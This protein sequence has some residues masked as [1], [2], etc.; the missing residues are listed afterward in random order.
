MNPYSAARNAAL[1]LVLLLA[2]CTTRSI[3][4]SGYPEG[5]RYGTSQVGG[6]TG[7]LSEFQVLGVTLD[8]TITEADIDAALKTKERPRLGPASR[9]LLI[10]SGADFP[11]APMLEALSARFSISSF[12]GKPP[13][14]DAGGV[15][16][17]RSLRLAAARGGYD[18][19]LC[20]WGILESERVNQ[21]TKYVSWV[22]IIGSAVPD[23][24]ERMRLR[25]KAAI[26]DVSSGR[27]TPVTPSPVASS[28]LSSM[29]NR[30]DTDQSLVA[31]LKETGYRNLT[32]LLVERHTE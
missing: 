7:E 29:Y 8:P 23:E 14:R 22:P 27:W 30:R 26:I 18:K 15:S 24:R 28:E 25:L 6:Y 12:S 31:R 9:I 13:A 16:Y 5:G 4:N 10:Q 11:D 3:S 19:I 21:V 17:A 1:V 32:A 2:G 20:Y